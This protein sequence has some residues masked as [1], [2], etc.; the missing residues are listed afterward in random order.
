MKNGD[1]IRNLSIADLEALLRI[2]RELGARDVEWRGRS[3][4]V[5]MILLEK[6]KTLF[7]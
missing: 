1:E 4:L 5:E 3:V 7:V 6:I 2:T